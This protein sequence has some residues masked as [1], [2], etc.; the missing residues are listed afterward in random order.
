MVDKKR[1]FF[2]LR[3]GWKA[4]DFRNKDYYARID[5]HEKSMY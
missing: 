5:H 1:K 3:N 2:E 4:V